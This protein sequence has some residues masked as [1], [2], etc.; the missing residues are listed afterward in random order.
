MHPSKLGYLDLSH[1]EQCHDYVNLLNTI[2]RHRRCSTNYCL[3][4]KQNESDLKRRFNYPFDLCD[5][6]RLEFEKIHTKDKSVKYRAKIVTKRN[7]TRLNNHQRV[8]L[9]GWRAN[10][11]IQV[12]IDHHAC[13]EYLVKGLNPG[14]ISKV[15]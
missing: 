4:H 3:K 15:G 1:D 5:K 12:I 7:D 14:V 6:N 8:Q 11:D 13:I 9:Q 2:Q 10:C